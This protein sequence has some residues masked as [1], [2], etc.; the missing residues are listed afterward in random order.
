MAGFNKNK[1]HLE[2]GMTKKQV[3]ADIVH[4]SQDTH[5]SALFIS[6]PTMTCR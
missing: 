4:E 2:N 5:L 3:M 6:V 1:K